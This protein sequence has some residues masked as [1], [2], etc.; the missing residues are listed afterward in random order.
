[1][2][3]LKSDDFLT[4]RAWH[5]SV[6]G[7]SDMI[8]RRVSALEFLEL[9]AGYMRETSIDVYAKHRGDYDNINYCIVNNY[10][11][12]EYSRFG[13]VLC[14]TLNQTI[15]DLLADFDNIDKQPLVEA[16]SSYY[17]ANGNSFDGLEINSENKAHF[18]VIKDWAVEY[19]DEE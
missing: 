6:I 5:S 13:N 3:S 11:G 7:G 19:Y 17:F 14:T 15:N 9:F 18:N 4:A 1:M 16:L 12:I 8:L 10:D 2:T